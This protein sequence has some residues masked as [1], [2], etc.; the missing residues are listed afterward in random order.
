[1]HIDMQLPKRALSPGLSLHS[2]GRQSQ[3]MVQHWVLS[4]A[5]GHSRNPGLAGDR[6]ASG[7]HAGTAGLAGRSVRTSG[8]VDGDLGVGAAAAAA[9]GPAGA[10][11]AATAATGPPGAATRPAGAPA[12][13]AAPRAGAGPARAAAAATSPA[14]APAGAARAGAAPVPAPLPPRPP[15]PPEPPPPVPPVRSTLVPP[16]VSGLQPRRLRPGTRAKVSRDRVRTRTR[17]MEAE[18]PRR[19]RQRQETGLVLRPDRLNLSNRAR[20]DDSTCPKRLPGD[21]ARFGAA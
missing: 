19:A 13:A 21:C 6:L 17:V 7:E 12:T 10:A 3:S 11:T 1:M 20:R 9:T 15:L 14:A 18:V 4:Q 16:P 2:S 8:G 5:L